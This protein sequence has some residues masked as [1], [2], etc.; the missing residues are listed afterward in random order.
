ML[1]GLVV[2][3]NLDLVSAVYVSLGLVD[4]LEIGKGVLF[5]LVVV[6]NLDLGMED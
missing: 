4:K 3:N 1:F 2:V 5:G 6:N